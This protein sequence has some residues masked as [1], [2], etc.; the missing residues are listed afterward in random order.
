[1]KKNQATTFAALLAA[2]TVGCL[3]AVPAASAQGAGLSYTSIS[4]ISG[5]GAHIVPS[6]DEGAEAGYLAGPA[7]VNSEEAGAVVPHITCPATGDAYLDQSVQIDSSNEATDQSA[8]LFIVE[9][10]NGGVADYYADT[11][12]GTLE[13]PT[14]FTVAAGNKVGALITDSSGSVKVES[15]NVST[16]QASTQSGTL[17]TGAVYH[18]WAMDQNSGLLASDP[19]PSFSTPIEFE[20][21][22]NGQPVSGEDPTAFDMYNGSD[23][24][25]STGALTSN[26]NDFYT[27]FVAAS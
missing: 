2:A 7:T 4:G 6:A 15:E 17:E 5:P 10:C 23:L 22:I 18:A 25:I 9:S 3:S 27:S 24:M 26:G 14:A 8:G 19:I 21:I 13:K 1:M 16:G 12:V 20:M 11:Y